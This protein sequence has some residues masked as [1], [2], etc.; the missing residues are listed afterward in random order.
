MEG[1]PVT[2]AGTGRT[3]QDKPA[4][5]HILRYLQ[6]E[7]IASESCVS[8]TRFKRGLDTI[9]CGFGNSTMQQAAYKGDS[10]E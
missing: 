8:Y 3:I 4:S 5:D 9:I 7:T 2:V 1:L 6:F 10:G